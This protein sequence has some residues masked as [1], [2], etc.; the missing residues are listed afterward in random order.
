MTARIHSSAAENIEIK[1]DA[2]EQINRLNEAI[3]VLETA[4]RLKLD[5]YVLGESSLLARF[6]GTMPSLKGIREKFD[7]VTNRYNLTLAEDAESGRNYI[8]VF[9]DRNFAGR[10]LEILAQSGF[11]E[12]DMSSVSTKEKIS[13]QL[14][15]AVE[16]LSLQKKKLHDA[17]RRIERLRSENREFLIK[18]EK[19]LAC[20]AEK[21]EAPLRF[22]ATKKAVLIKGWVPEREIGRLKHEIRKLTDDKVYIEG[23]LPEKKEAVPIKLKH[24]LITK[25]Y[26]F[27]VRLYELPNYKE[28]DPTILLFLTFP[29]FFGIMLGDVGYGLVASLLFIAL[30]IKMPQFKALLN[31]M[32]L[33][34]LVSICFG[35]GF[36]EYF[37]FE[38]VSQKTGENLCSNYGICLE[39]TALEEGGSSHEKEA[40]AA[41]GVASEAASEN[42][43][44]TDT[45]AA[46]ANF[47]ETKPKSEAQKPKAAEKA[48]A[49]AMETEENKDKNEDN[50][51]EITYV[52][53]FPRLFNRLHGKMNIFG[54][55][56]LSILVVG[57]MIGFA[58]LNL[59]L[60]VGFYNIW[61]ARGFKHAFLEK[62]SW[63]VMEAGV[64][65]IAL[66]YTG[67]YPLK[68]IVV[69]AVFV[70][71]VVMI[72]FGDGV[73]GLV[74]LPAIFSNML[75]Y[76]RLGAV[77]LASVGLAVVVNENLAMPF[78]EKGGIYI[79]F[80]ILI[81][82]FG[83]LINIALGV[84]GPFLHSLRLHYVEFFTKFYSGGGIE[85]RPFGEREEND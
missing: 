7:R 85:Y 30:R 9:A 35:A 47:G 62:I 50:R 11:S 15:N 60:L 55:E 3:K 63:M 23:I 39:K 72:Y 4:K 10:F 24:S 81:L 19:L 37:G 51:E 66:R 54:F 70:L 14:I 58:H 68:S 49:E 44:G 52:Y 26:E 61:V 40:Q 46:A 8:A 27:F 84:I 56:V 34:S 43:A 5:N 20:E 53:E 71:G 31:I 28:I 76:M 17:A 16:R 80:G 41:F 79:L 36:G 67:A 48:A 33:A 78:M 59:G 25:P 21:A 6:I 29:I 2:E 32:I 65:L 77:G 18:N 73:Q 42:D 45:G 22:G 75:S 82:I 57:V 1:K 12:L 64:I 13:S 83:H 74:E 69:W 38:Y